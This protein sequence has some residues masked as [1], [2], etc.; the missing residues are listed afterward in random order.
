MIET[1]SLISSTGTAPAGR[2]YNVAIAGF[3]PVGATLAGL[4]GRAGL[5]VRVHEKSQEIYP[6][7]RAVGFDQDAMRIFQHIGIAEALAP[8]VAPFRDGVYYGVEGQMIQRVRRIAPPYPLTWDPN[9]TCDQPGL[10]SVL[11]EALSRV[12]HVSISLGRELTDFEE[13]DHRVHLRSTDAAGNVFHDT[14]DYLVACDGASSPVRRKLGI[15]LESMDYDEPWIVVDVIVNED[16]IGRLPTTNVQYCQ[17][18]RPSSFITCPGNHRRWEFMTLPGE[19]DAGV[20]PEERLWRLLSRWLKPDQARIWRAAAYRFHA[21]IADQ[22]RSGRVLLAGD[23]AHQTPPFLGQGMCQGLRDVGNLAWKLE[24]VIRG[25]APQA[26]LDTYMQERRPHVVETTRMAKAFGCIISERDPQKARERDARMLG[27]GADG[28][29]GEPKTLYR[30]DLIPG[31][32]HGLISTRAP[33]AGKVFPQPRVSRAG[34]TPMLMDDLAAPDWRLVLGARAALPWSEAFIVLARK[35]GVQPI[36]VGD[37]GMPRRAGV[38]A[39]AESEG[40]L[41]GWFET[42]RCAGALVRPDFYVF[43]TF[44]SMDAAAYLLDE[45]AAASREESVAAPALNT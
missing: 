45:W 17:P 41:Q 21:L 18:E 42:H 13:R 10:E 40:L 19:P 12:P 35:H 3:G 33:L 1:N 37:A 28:Q 29:P 26:L 44:D 22:W 14:A 31:L 5:S 23:S 25:V 16:S 30:Q 7:P 39:V 24:K 2:H 20:I 32:A 11:R 43:G 34:A 9:Y 4:L 8:F 6:Q 38:I 27:T 15:T 36:I